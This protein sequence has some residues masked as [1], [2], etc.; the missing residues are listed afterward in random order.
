[1]VD[2]LKNDILFNMLDVALPPFKFPYIEQP[3]LRQ[4]DRQNANSEGTDDLIA[5][6]L[7][8][9][10]TRDEQ[11]NT[12]LAFAYYKESAQMA[13]FRG[14]IQVFELLKFQKDPNTFL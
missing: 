11:N 10:H 8:E 13:L 12:K 14:N 2:L 5:K 1:M 9:F 7:Q 4:I 3:K 6:C